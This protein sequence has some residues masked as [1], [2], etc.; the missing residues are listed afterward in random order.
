M[1]Q[2]YRIHQSLKHDIK[3]CQ[4]LQRLEFIKLLE[5]NNN[6]NVEISYTVMTK[7]KIEERLKNISMI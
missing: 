6:K 2:L 4:Q 5:K 7:H 1:Y 3:K